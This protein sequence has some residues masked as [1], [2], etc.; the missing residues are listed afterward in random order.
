MLLT[1]YFW[2]RSVK[3]GSI[4]SSVLCS[5]AYFYMV[6][7]FVFPL[8]LPPN[9]RNPLQLG[10]LRVPDQ[11]DS[12]ACAGPDLHWQIL[13][14]HLHRIFH[15]LHTG[16]NFVHA[17]SIRGLPTGYHLRAHGSECGLLPISLWPKFDLISSTPC[18]HSACSV[19]ARSWPLPSGCARKCRPIAFK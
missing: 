7:R 18:R 14:S 13:P 5:L 12:P 16:H 4:F 1:Y 8:A 10:R 3:T 6:S 11:S 15:C 9:P 2:I 17:N 19:S